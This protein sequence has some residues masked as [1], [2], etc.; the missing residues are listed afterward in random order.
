MTLGLQSASSS[1]LSVPR[2]LRMIEITRRFLAFLAACGLAVS[3]LGYVDS[4]TRAIHDNSRWLVMLAIGALA[5]QIAIYAL[6]YP[7]SKD[8]NFFWKGFTRGMPSWVAPCI[9][10]FWLITVAHFVWFF[11][12]TGAGVPI[13]KDGQYV[14]SNRGRILKVISQTDY[15]RLKEGELRMFAALMISC[16]LVPTIYWWFPRT[17]QQA[18]SDQSPSP[19]RT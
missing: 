18:V 12:Q 1:T 3:V 14:L 17:N 5:L 15:L 13:I 11:V 10:V 7:A 8:R 2:M 19:N 9:K 4:F 6:E 16:Y